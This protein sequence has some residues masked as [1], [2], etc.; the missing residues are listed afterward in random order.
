MR[1]QQY[2]SRVLN[3]M[4]TKSITFAL[5]AVLSLYLT[6]TALC[7][8]CQ[9][10]DIKLEPTPDTENQVPTTAATDDAVKTK[11][12]VS[13]KLKPDNIFLIDTFD[14]KQQFDKSWVHSSDS[15]YAGKFELSSGSD[16]PEA[17]LQLVL[18]LKARRYAI[19]SKLNSPF[20]FTDNKPLI[21]QY[22][23]QYRDGNECGGSYVK[24]LRQAVSKDLSLVNEKTPYTIMFGP[25]KCGNEVKIHFIVQYLNPKTQEYEEK[26]WTSAKLVSNLLQ[27]FNDKKHHLFRLVLEPSNNFE[28]FLD[29]K[30]VGK[31]SLLSDLEPAINP[32]AEIVDVNDKKPENWDDRPQIDDPE[33]KKPEDWDEDAPITTADPSAQK[34]DDWLED[35]P[36]DIPDPDAKKPDDWEE[37]DGEWQAPLIANPKCSKVSGCGKWSAPQIPNPAFKGK[38][39]PEKIKNP[40]YKGAWKARMI[41]NPDYFFDESPFASLDSIGAVSFELWSMADNVAFDNLILASDLKPVNLLQLLTW[42]SKK[43]EADAS[44][45]SLQTRIAHYLKEYPWLWAVL[46]ISVALPLVLFIAYCCDYSGSRKRAAEAAERKKTD[47]SRP[48]DKKRG[49]GV[50]ADD[51]EDD[52][53]ENEDEDAGEAEDDEEEQ[54][55]EEEEA[56]E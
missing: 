39:K 6:F 47:K 34:P 29:D 40:N 43:A 16:R 22:E 30:S 38:W 33:A 12:Y 2:K 26:H 53:D 55:G 41:P 23:V 7:V 32:P 3:Q 10:D 25:D 36:Q 5:L 21:V 52:E 24:L 14:D 49:N 27:V 45:P 48:D 51:E 50:A 35:E 20:K 46:A 56:V 54:E 13:P 17:D 31:G 4:S 9:S 28:V 37:M 15:Q 18:P 11:A 44:S 1:D 19:S 42:Q 8:S